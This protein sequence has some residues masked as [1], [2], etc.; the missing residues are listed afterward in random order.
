MKKSHSPLRWSLCRAWRHGCEVA[1]AAAG[2]EAK[3]PE[4]CEDRPPLDALSVS[5]RFGHHF[6][7]VLQNAIKKLPVFVREPVGLLLFFA[8]RKGCV[9]LKEVADIGTAP[10]DELGEPVAAR[11]PSILAGPVR[12]SG[13]GRRSLGSAA[14]AT[15]GTRPPYRCEV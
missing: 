2:L 5:A 12:S 6:A 11:C 8:I 13:Q 15:T 4:Q 14:P 1:A 7:G 3:S 9:G 10:L